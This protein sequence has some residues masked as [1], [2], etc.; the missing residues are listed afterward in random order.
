MN[1][2]DLPNNVDAAVLID[3]LNSWAVDKD[4]FQSTLL[5][6]RSG[7]VVTQQTALNNTFKVDATR[8]DGLASGTTGG[9]GIAA[10]ASTQIQFNQ[11]GNLAGDSEFTW[12]TV[13][14]HLGVTGTANITGGLSAGALEVSNNAL[15]G[16]TLTVGNI[17]GTS[18]SLGGNLAVGGW[19]TVAA[20]TS[21][22]GF[23]V[24]GQSMRVTNGIS[25]GGSFVAGGSLVIAG[26]LSVSNNS[27]IGATMDFNAVSLRPLTNLTGSLG[28]VT[29][30]WGNVFGSSGNFSQFTVGSTLAGPSGM[31]V[32]GAGMFING[33]IEVGSTLTVAGGVAQNWNKEPAS[34]VSIGIPTVRW[35]GEF[36]AGVAGWTKGADVASGQTVV[37]IGDGNY[38]DLTG[39]TAISGLSSIVHPQTSHYHDSGTV[40][41]LHLDSNP[42]IANGVGLSLS[43]ATAYQGAT[44]DVLGFLMEGP[45]LAREIFRHQASPRPVDITFNT[46]SL[47][48]LGMTSA[49]QQFP[50]GSTRYVPL[51]ARA[52]R[53]VRIYSQVITK[54]ATDAFLFAEGSTNGG[55][56]WWAISTAALGPGV[57]ID[58]AGMTYSPWHGLTASAMH[59]DL[60]LRIIGFSG[61]GMDS[62]NFAT[63]GLQFR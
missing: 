47:N 38:F 57:Q 14:K 21:L 51:D 34:T 28:Q 30:R 1:W 36:L 48:V 29:R 62:P 8:V 54:G 20:G 60:L 45:A 11:A 9:G 59:Q 37:L 4:R 3:Q 31:V 50:G 17:S 18:I 53:E 32:S 13:A 26:G 22:T 56:N 10:G 23:V 12:H 63:T 43:G 7:K 52:F 42:A 40:V 35:N 33:Q 6:P 49:A 55:A 44:D 25:A 41:V 39:A 2:K 27:L 24:L 46:A 58:A 5:K 15:I 19:L 61:D 16:G